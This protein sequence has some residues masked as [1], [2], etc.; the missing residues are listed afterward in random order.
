MSIDLIIV[1]HNSIDQVASCL[2]SV[3]GTP[4]AD[5]YEFIVI[6]NNSLDNDFK[7]LAIYSLNVIVYQLSSNFGFAIANNIGAKLTDSEYL[8]FL[9]PDT[10]VTEDFITPILNFISKDPQ[11]GVCAPMLVYED[12]SYQSSSGFKMGVWYDF[13]EAFY[14]IGLVRKL[15]RMKYLK[16]EKS[17]LPVKVGWVSGACMIVKRSV[18]EQVGGFSED[19]FLNYEDID[20]CRKIE[21]AGFTNYYFPSYKCTH[22]DHKSFDKNYELLVLSRYQS[23]LIYARLHYNFLQRIVSR[24]FHI[25]GIMIRLFAVNIFYSGNERKSRLSGYFKALTLY[26]NPNSK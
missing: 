13:L 16:S 1:N 5:S 23:R 3:A 8:C 6:D 15:N 7:L 9:N 19:Y 18:F 25:N 10:I 14:L 26:L 24:L 11:A 21:D 20:L 12:G 22:L 2:K 17:L 4:T